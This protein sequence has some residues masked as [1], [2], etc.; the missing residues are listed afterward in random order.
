MWDKLI[1][2][3]FIL[4]MFKQV[5]QDQNRVFTFV[6]KIQ[7]SNL[8][9]VFF[10]FATYIGCPQPKGC[11]IPNFYYDQFSIIYLFIHL[12][13][14]LFIYSFNPFIAIYLNLLSLKRICS[15][16]TVH[17]VWGWKAACGV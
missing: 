5:E 14:Y 1:N 9:F 12:F 8:G 6:Y 3:L 2:R 7:D 10:F 4:N 17:F 15:L 16:G 13:I 11:T